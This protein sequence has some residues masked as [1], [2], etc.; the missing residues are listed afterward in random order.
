M[1]NN[2]PISRLTFPNILPPLEPTKGYIH[3]VLDMLVHPQS[4]TESVNHLRHPIPR[5]SITEVEIKK[6]NNMD[7]PIPQ[8][9]LGKISG[10]VQTVTAIYTSYIYICMY[11]ETSL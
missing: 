11:S 2:S 8:P 10:A 6:I 4:H 7:F 9:T 3:K 1:A 5:T